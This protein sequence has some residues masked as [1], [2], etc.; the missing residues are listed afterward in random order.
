[1]RDPLSI[2]RFLLAPNNSF[3]PDVARALAKTL[4]SNETITKLDLG[5]NTLGPKGLQAR[6]IDVALSLS[7]ES[8]RALFGILIL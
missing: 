3:T 6:A 7:F 8:L 1:M 5:L 4:E 2:V